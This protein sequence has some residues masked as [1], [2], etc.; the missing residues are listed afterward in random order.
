MRRCLVS[1]IAITIS[2]KHSSNTFLEHWSS[3]ITRVPD[4]LQRSPGTP[5]FAKRAFLG[6]M[7]DRTVALVAA[8]ADI[9][10]GAPLT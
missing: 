7:I 3:S 4:S 1:I 9:F 8:K 2:V 6:P 5:L 10:Y